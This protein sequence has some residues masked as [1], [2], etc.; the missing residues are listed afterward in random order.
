MYTAHCTSCMYMLHVWFGSANTLNDTTMNSEQSC[1]Q[2]ICCSPHSVLSPGHASAAG[3]AS[4]LEQLQWLPVT[5][6]Q[7]A[8]AS[9]SAAAACAL[10]HP[11]PSASSAVA[12]PVNQTVVN[13]ISSGMHSLAVF[14]QALVFAVPER[15]AEHADA[16]L[17]AAAAS[18][19]SAC[20]ASPRHQISFNR[21]QACLS[22]DAA[23]FEER[24]RASCRAW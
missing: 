24:A 2:Y 20:S 11:A 22:G 12:C 17:S 15:A 8:D 19:S 9:L 3:A 1:T 5:V 23:S 16:S 10:L 21:V 4:Q 18:A 14:R 7:H 13:R 6:A